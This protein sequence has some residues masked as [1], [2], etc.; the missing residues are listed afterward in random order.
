MSMRALRE[1]WLVCAMFAL[2]VTS[3]ARAEDKRD[4]EELDLS[5]LLGMELDDQLGTTE[6]VSRAEERVLSSPPR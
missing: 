2:V 6:A 1:S 5:S 4:V 3:V